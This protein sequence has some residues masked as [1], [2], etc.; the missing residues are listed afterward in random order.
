VPD[1]SFDFVVSFQVLEHVRS[2]EHIFSECIRVIKPG[3]I[4]YHVV[5]NYKSFY[6]GHYAI[7][8]LPF[9]NKSLGRLYL[10]MLGRDT[11]QFE[12]LNLVKPRAVV[13]AL[14]NCKDKLKVIS[15]GRA[16]FV[17]KFNR[18]QIDK[19]N[20]RFLRAV[21]KGVFALPLLK[22]GLLNLI[23]LSNLYY[24]ITVIARRL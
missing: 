9:L 18:H 1:A 5:P 8:W 17:N 15:L 2:I 12:G 20:Q 13:K 14:R 4:M 3:G 19:V 23:A 24:P 7:M 6:E 21:L 22:D 11:A 16:E 10:R